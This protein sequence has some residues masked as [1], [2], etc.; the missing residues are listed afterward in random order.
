MGGIRQGSEPGGDPPEAAR[1][2][3]PPG[4]TARGV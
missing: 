3:L 4:T 1:R 2:R